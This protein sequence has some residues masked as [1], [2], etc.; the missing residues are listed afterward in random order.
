MEEGTIEQELAACRLCP[1]GC[2]VNRLAGKKGRCGVAGRVK[3][4]R[5]ALHMWEEPCISGEQGSGAVFFAG[6]SLG[7][8]YCQ[9]RTIAGGQAGKEISVRRL[10]EIF[11]QLQEKG[12]ANINLV[13][14]GH[15][16]P[17][18]IEALIKAKK[19]G[20]RLP[21]VYNSGGYERAEALARLEGLVDIYLPDLKYVSADLAGQYSGAPDYFTVASAALKEMVR[22]VEA[23]GSGS[24]VFTE[25]GMMKRGVIV[26]HLQLP[27]CLADSKRVVRYLYETYGDRIFIS[28]LSQYT[29]LAQ[30]AA[31]PKLN[32][33][34]T[35]REYDA[36][37]DYA[38]GLGVENGFI[39]E[40]DTAQESF[41]PPFD[42]EG[43]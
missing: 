18:V 35:R 4:A 11:L 6:C 13:T 1:R 32:R 30:M 39:Q 29:P 22:Q 12:A 37:V 23:A 10:S 27:G 14:A 3:V 17:Q 21:V 42:E 24:A 7:C 38:I 31:W 43:V 36:L 16:L 19:E 15:F 8:V 5:A 2:G 34:V 33:R 20:L 40:G 9:N 28:L 25:K 41:I 26:R